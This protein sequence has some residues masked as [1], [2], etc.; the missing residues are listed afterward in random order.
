MG[1][2]V[3]GATRHDLKNQET[4]LEA[5]GEAIDINKHYLT[6]GQAQKGCYYRVET[7]S[8]YSTQVV[9]GEKIELG[10]IVVRSDQSPSWCQ[11]RIGCTGGIWRQAW[12]TPSDTIT[13]D[14]PLK[15]AGAQDASDDESSGSGAARTITVLIIVALL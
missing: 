8:K 15:D 13:V 12:K 4:Y 1:A 10:F 9:A 3:G 7:V 5:M 14:C 2:P 11:E 6:S